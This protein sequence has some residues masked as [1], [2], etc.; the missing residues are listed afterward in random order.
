MANYP[1]D[2]KY[3]IDIQDYPYIE[4]QIPAAARKK[5]QLEHIVEESGWSDEQIHLIVRNIALAVFILLYFVLIAFFLAPPVERLFQGEVGTYKVY[6][7]HKKVVTPDNVEIPYQRD[8]L[9]GIIYFS[10]FMPDGEEVRMNS[11][12]PG[13]QTEFTTK[14]TLTPTENDIWYALMEV[15]DSISSQN[16]SVPYGMLQFFAV[17]FGL[18]CFRYPYAY[19]DFG[20]FLFIFH[21]RFFNSRKFALGCQIF[22]IAFA[23]ISLTPWAGQLYYTSFMEFSGKIF[24]GWAVGLGFTIM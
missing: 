12:Y 7:Y 17:L 2:P 10:L 8:H 4:T 9:A 19:G 23:L 18:S 3:Q 22:G 6:H 5:T 14:S 1:G 16:N 21:E 20:T 11:K 13:M 24:M 15:E